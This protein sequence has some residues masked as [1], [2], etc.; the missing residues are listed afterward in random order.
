MKFLRIFFLLAIAATISCTGSKNESSESSTSTVSVKTDKTNNKAVI[1]A[2]KC[3]IAMDY[4]YEKLLTKED[5]AKHTSIDEAS[6]KKD[7]SPTHGEYGSCTYTWDSDR[8]DISMTTSGMTFN[9]PDQN[10]ATVKSLKIHNEDDL[11]LYNQSDVISLFETAYKK[12]S[13]QEYDEMIARLES[14]YANDPDRLNQAKGFADARMNL[15]YGPVDNL[16]ERAYWKWSDKFGIELVVLQG[17]VQFIIAAKTSSSA[18]TSL[19]VAINL[20]KEVLSKCN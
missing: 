2:A 17:A 8:P 11:K 13:R 18:E 6:F 20:A 14:E 9:L 7:V 15:D 19:P 1:D 5:V 4:D 16:G 10:L 12:M 3:F